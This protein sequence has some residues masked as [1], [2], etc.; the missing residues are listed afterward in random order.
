MIQSGTKFISIN[1]DGSLSRIWTVDEILL[2]NT[3]WARYDDTAYTVSSPYTFST[4]EFNIPNNAGNAITT[5]INS[6]IDFYDGSKIYS[7]YKNDVYLI[8]VA[9]KIKISNSNGY[10]DIF[11]E[12]GNGTPYDRVRDTITFPKGNGVEHTYSRMFQYYSDEDVVEN[13]LTLKAISSHNGEIYDIIFFIQRTQK[14][15]I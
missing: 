15:S 2:Y 9:F 5:N 14:F 4:V 11:L 13:G 8:T 3:S 7:E 1:S 6:S 10:M 12:G